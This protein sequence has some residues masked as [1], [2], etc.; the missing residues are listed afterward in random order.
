MTKNN[1][2]CNNSFNNNNLKAP[3][4]TFGLIKSTGFAFH[5]LLLPL[6]H[7]YLATSSEPGTVDDNEKYTLYTHV[8]LP[9]Q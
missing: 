8:T 2:I 3:Y 4:C 9:C 6:Q 1:D 5:I 7:E